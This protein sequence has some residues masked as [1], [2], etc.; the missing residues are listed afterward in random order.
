M[1]REL[2]RQACRRI[3]T[4]AREAANSGGIP[5]GIGTL[6]EK[7]LHEGTEQEHEHEAVEHHAHDSQLDEEVEVLVVRMGL[8]LLQLVIE[9]EDH[10]K[11]P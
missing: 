11:V 5:Q 8:G 4:E 6:G 7:T 10:G 3:I 9:G 1:D 2:F